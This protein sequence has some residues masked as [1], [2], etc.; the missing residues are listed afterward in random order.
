MAP[1]VHLALALFFLPTLIL[2]EPLHVS[3]T[4]RR[5]TK[6]I[7]NWADEANKLRVKYGYP[8]ATSQRRRSSRRATSAGIPILDQGGDSSYIAN[9]TIGT[10]PQ[11]FEVVLDTGS[12]DL[13][14][15]GS[16]C[17]TCTA[18]SPIFDTSTSSTF[19]GTPTS[20]SLGSEV[21]I[22]Y[23]SGEVRGTLGSDTVTMGGSTVPSQTFLTV[24]AMTTGLVNAP[25]SGLM[26]LAFESLASTQA[27]PFWQTVTNNNQLSNPEMSFWLA[28]DLH[29]LSEDFLASGGVFTLGGTNSTFFSGNI[30]FLSLAS[31]PSF[32]LL[33]LA[34]LTVNGK[35]VKLT[36]P[37]P[38]SAI[39]TGTTLIGG[40]HNDVV[41]LYNSI[42]GSVD[43]GNSDPGFF[44][45]PCNTNITVAMS[46]GGQSWPINPEDFNAGQVNN[47]RNP[48]CLGAIFDLSLGVNNA[49]DSAS[50]TWVV[51]DTFL[52][53]VYTVFRSSPPS[54]GFAQLSAAA[55]GSGTAAPGSASGSPAAGG[56]GTAGSFPTGISFSSAVMHT[57]FSSFLMLSTVTTVIMLSL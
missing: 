35:P 47:G 13:W 10:P 49:Q 53:N 30:E 15:P 5:Q 52:K 54:V 55:G 7:S 46:F 14:L 12:S 28:R 31:T 21:S 3:L 39:D 20:S 51:G 34:S 17:P 41:A 40:P 45:Y 50:P 2:S 32:W 27:T 25:V 9:L 16:N 26:G 23:G 38:L 1:A 29:P 43:L 36:T 42:P 11:S 8:L 56:T 19:K 24:D 37:D 6:L 48:L 57:T 22:A 44:A 33:S 18:G 4:H